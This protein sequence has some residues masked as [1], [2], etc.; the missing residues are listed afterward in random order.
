MAFQGNKANFFKGTSD[1]IYK[2]LFAFRVIRK[3]ITQVNAGN[4]LHSIIFY[5]RKVT[6]FLHK[7]RKIIPIK[8]LELWQ[9][10]TFER[11]L[12]LSRWKRLGYVAHRVLGRFQRDKWQE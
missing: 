1:F 7:C 4:V 8:V 2:F 3:E 5:I 11:P 6:T 12:H 9:V 10:R